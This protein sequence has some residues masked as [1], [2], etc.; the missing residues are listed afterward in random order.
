MSEEEDNAKIQ[1]AINM[2][3]EVKKPMNIDG[4]SF[5]LGTNMMKGKVK[6]LMSARARESR[7]VDPKVQLSADE[8]KEVR[9]YRAVKES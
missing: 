9:R 1:S 6:V 5:S 8:F 2:F 3:E 7:A 4:H